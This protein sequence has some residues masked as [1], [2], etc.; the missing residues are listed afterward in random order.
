[1]AQAAPWPS[2]FL[3]PS[4]PFAGAGAPASEP[5]PHWCARCPACPRLVPRVALC[6]RRSSGAR[7]LV[8]ASRAYGYYVSFRNVERELRAFNARRDASAGSD[9]SGVMPSSC[10]L[11]AA[12]RSDLDTA[13]MRHGGYGHVAG[14]LGLA[15]RYRRR[16][17]WCHFD[18]V[19]RE[20]HAFVS[21]HRLVLDEPGAPPGTLRMPTQRELREHGHASLAAALERHGGIVTCARGMGLPVATRASGST[22]ACDA[23]DA[24][25]PI[26]RKPPGYWSSF[27]NLARELN[28]FIDMHAESGGAR[29]MPTR[30]GLRAAGRADLTDA[31]DYHGGS[32]R[33]AQRLGVLPT[34]RMRSSRDEFW[35]LAHELYAI[36]GSGWMP[37]AQRLDALGR[38]DLASAVVR[39]GGKKRVARAL[40]LRYANVNVEMRERLRE[41]GARSPSALR[42][43]SGDFRTGCAELRRLARERGQPDAMPT[44]EYLRARARDDLVALIECHGGFDAVAE[45]LRLRA[46]PN[47]PRFAD[48]AREVLSMM[49]RDGPPG[50][51]PSVA[52]LR[53]AGRAELADAV[54]RVGADQVSQRL[55]LQRCEH[56]AA[57]AG[58]STPPSPQPSP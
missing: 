57:T 58:P 30:A 49:Q 37:S 26:P 29:R 5:A 36:S 45:R 31:L 43:R 42:G 41:R 47:H 38:R 19:A 27:D 48:V 44:A 25:Q 16:G 33:V 35:P 32:A 13:I 46:A 28:A 51:M 10:E 39:F 20:L 22:G 21:K 14:R 54:E 12:R 17:Y 8:A 1:M 50:T 52:A 9:G 7:D 56:P 11:L 18:N 2:L 34:V 55:G 15:T 40:G 23:D 4:A 53:H 3:S 24:R 6:R